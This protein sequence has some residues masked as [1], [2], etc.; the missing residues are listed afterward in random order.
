[1]GR[2]CSSA[3]AIVA[4]QRA[5]SK[6]PGQVACTTM[7]RSTTVRS[8]NAAFQH[9]E[10]LRRNRT[11]RTH[12]GEF[13]V[14]GVKPISRALEH[15]WQFRQLWFDTERPLTAWADDVLSRTGKAERVGT[16]AELMAELSEREEPSELVAVMAMQDDSSRLDAVVADQG[17]LLLVLDRPTNP[18]NVGS[19]I[20]TADALG[21]SAVVITGHAVDPY[22]PQCVRASMG[23]LFA[24]PVVRLPSPT[25]LFDVCS[26]YRSLLPGLLV[27]GAGAPVDA[28]IETVDLTGPRVVVMGNEADGLSA[29]YRQHCDAIIHIP[30]QGRAADSLNVSAAA[31][32][33]LYEVDRQRR[34]ATF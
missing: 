28:S 7:Q 32:I 21:A 30:M 4:R 8:R 13:V 22:D 5:A 1:M 23:S 26:R 20:R 2:R 29:A 10:T 27:L 14:E 6:E 34:Y 18:G 9:V 16:T 25:A 33:I 11:K 3:W 17:L 19:M 31:A 12:H 24:L 15:G